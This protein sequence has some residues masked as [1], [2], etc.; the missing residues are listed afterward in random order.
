MRNL[1]EQDHPKAQK[2][3]LREIQHIGVAF[4]QQSFQESKIHPG[5]NDN[6]P[7]LHRSGRE[8]LVS[9]LLPLEITG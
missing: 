7:A 1:I 3:L 2:N 9:G 5:A 6:E 8:G 4:L